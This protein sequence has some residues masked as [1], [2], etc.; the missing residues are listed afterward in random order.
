MSLQLSFATFDG[1]NS[2]KSK[3]ASNGE[4]IVTS[5]NAKNSGIPAVTYSFPTPQGDTGGGSATSDGSGEIDGTVTTKD[6]PAGTDP[7]TPS[8]T[9]GGGGGTGS[10]PPPKTNT[11]GG[12]GKINPKLDNTPPPTEPPCNA[13]T[14][15]FNFEW[16]LNKAEPKYPNKALFDIVL[17]GSRWLPCNKTAQVVITSPFNKDPYKYY[18]DWP[19]VPYNIMLDRAKYIETRLLQYT[20]TPKASFL[21]HSILFNQSG[22]PKG[23]IIMK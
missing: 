20:K 19:G 4:T 12:G 23:S 6:I 15:S 21:P 5:Q 9:G 16:I 11:G 18:D 3:V 17:N 14:G 22:S 8:T 7:T 1:T 10:I 2:W 13:F